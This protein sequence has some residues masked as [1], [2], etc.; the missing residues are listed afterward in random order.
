MSSLV[1]RDSNLIELNQFIT[2]SATISNW[3][4]SDRGQTIPY[5]DVMKRVHQ[6]VDGKKLSY[7]TQEG[8]HFTSLAR[9]LIKLRGQQLNADKAK[10]PILSFLF[11]RCPAFS[12][13]AVVL[14][15]ARAILRNIY[16]DSSG[17]FASRGPMVFPDR[18]SW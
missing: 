11:C 9:K 15:L 7:I 14:D 6:L 3:I 1:V 4:I 5:G 13:E 8:Q 18:T 2:E 16:W 12:G 17:Y 10:S